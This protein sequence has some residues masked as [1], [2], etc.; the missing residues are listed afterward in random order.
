MTDQSVLIDI[1]Y[2]YKISNLYTS[3]EYN[4]FPQY[5]LIYYFNKLLY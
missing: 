5:F 2:I 4:N 1:K 3:T